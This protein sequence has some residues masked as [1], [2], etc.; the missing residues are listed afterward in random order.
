MAARRIHV[1]LLAGSDTVGDP[2]VH[3]TSAIS[4]RTDSDARSQAIRLRLAHGVLALLAII[5]AVGLWVRVANLAG[6][7]LNI[8]EVLH[9]FAARSLLAGNGPMLPS[10]RPYRR[11][12]PYTDAVAIA[13]R[14]GG[15]NEWTA[16][17]PSV[18]FGTLTIVLVFLM[19]RAWYGRDRF[20]SG[21]VTALAPMQIA[22]SREARMYTAFE[23]CFLLGVFAF[24]LGFES[25]ARTAQA[26]SR[27]RYATGATRTVSG[28]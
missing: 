17:V 6:P 15:V 19:G 26:E 9:V 13:G 5:L 4:V 18:I 21:I 10:G 20:G 23:F 28:Q 8:D 11:A 1:W 22:F 25:T 7:D 2:G 3:I 27:S 16:R 14:F 24:Y 12:M